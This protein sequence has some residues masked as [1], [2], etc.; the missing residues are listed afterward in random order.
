MQDSGRVTFKG[1]FEKGKRTQKLTA[2]AL[3]YLAES[4]GTVIWWGQSSLLFLHKVINSQVPKENKDNAVCFL[5]L[6]IPLEKVSR[7]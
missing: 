4:E 5:T 2:W 7:G 3:N 1:S 6:E